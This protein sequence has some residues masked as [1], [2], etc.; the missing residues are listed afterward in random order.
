MKTVKRKSIRQDLEQLAQQSQHKT[1][2]QKP[3]NKSKNYHKLGLNWKDAVIFSLVMFYT[4]LYQINVNAQGLDTSID[5]DDIS[6]GMMMRF[7]KTT[8]EYHSLY[9]ANTEYEVDVFGLSTEDD[10]RR[11]GD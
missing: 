3:E 6:S 5:F 10:G 8:G 1:T 7:N 4:T 9:L 2:K 11:A